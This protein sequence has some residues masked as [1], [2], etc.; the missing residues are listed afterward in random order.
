MKKI[1]LQFICASLFIYFN[2]L[3]AQTKPLQIEE[4]KLKNGL[5]VRMIQ[6][7]SIPAVTIGCY[8]NVGKKTETPGQQY[9]AS[10]LSE[11]L[12]LG[13]EKYTRIEQDNLLAKLGSSISPVC[14]DNFT[15][16]KMRFLDKDASTAME[17]FSNILLKPTLAEDKIKIRIEELLNYNNPYKM[18]ISDIADM[19]S[20]YVVFSTAN[21][22]GRHF[23]A[24]QLNKINATQLREFYKFNY[25]PKNTKLILAGNFDVPKMK[26]TLEKLFGSWAAAYGENNGSAYETDDI[27]GKEYYFVNKKKATQTYLQWNKK[28]PE[29]GSKDATLFR[30]ASNALNTL[31]FDEIRAK[32]GKTYGIRCSY[33]E[34]DNNGIY[35]VS[36]QV[37]NEVAYET[38]VSFDRVLKQ[39]YETGL[40]QEQLDKAKAAIKNRRL[41]IETPSS[42]IDF[43]NP[44]LYKDTKKRDE[45]LTYID[46]ITLEQVNKGVKKYFS[47]SSYKLVIVG[48]ENVV[49]SQLQK[50]NTLVKLPVTSIEKDN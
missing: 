2:Q 22:L 12:L 40:T 31:L 32:E 15:E 35:N 1:I 8:V 7:G 13:N 10:L 49:G 11:A 33:D 19:F 27:K 39:F 18:D 21:P 17:L 30:L 3:H 25:T 28:A 44:L 23:Y 38:T 24:A 4:F 48:D 26:E 41:A 6:Y 20:S 34:A 43:Y 45:F 36:T 50:I 14:N 29:G 16:L 42:I 9:M 37:R 5:A 47:P 46:A